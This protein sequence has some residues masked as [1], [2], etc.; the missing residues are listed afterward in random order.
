MQES[1]STKPSR[2]LEIV[3]AALI[4]T[5]VL[6]AGALYA[7]AYAFS[8]T[9]IRYPLH[10]HFHFR[11]VLVSSGKEVNFADNSFQTDY[12]KDVCSA[13]LTK[14][15]IH[16][17]DHNAQYGHIHWEGMTGGLVLKNYGWNFIGG[18][19]GV[20][21][22]RFD[23]GMIPQTVPVHGNALPT[24][25][26]GVNYYAYTGTSTQHSQRSWSDFLHQPLNKFLAGTQVVDPSEAPELVA[27]DMSAEQMN[28]VVGNMVIFA[29][30]DAPSAE[31]VTAK[32]KEIKPAPDSPCE[33]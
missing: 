13:A 14:Q 20:L 27:Q 6:V 22:Y 9:S 29:Q 23:K 10:T 8:P 7:G 4:A 15:P 31:Q 25:T 2:K 28:D 16:F 17:H 19:P 12:S 11:I 21:G 1:A 32:F 5:L 3:L 24:R 33:G 26:D 30:K 18:L